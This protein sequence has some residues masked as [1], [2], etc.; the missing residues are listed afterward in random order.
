MNPLFSILMGLMPKF[1][2]TAYNLDAVTAST[3]AKIEKKFRDNLST[4][5]PFFLKLKEQGGLELVNGGKELTYPVII[6]DGNAA[7]YYGDD[8]MQI[9]RPEG[10]Q[11][12]TYSWKQFYSTIRI[13]GIEE[14]M[15]A[16]EG[17]GAK[18]LDG[19]MEQAEV[20]TANK[21]E[22]MLFGDSTGNPGG[23]SVARDWNGLRDLI[24]DTPTTG[25]IGG[26]SRVTYTKLRNQ[27]Y[28]TTISAFN[29]S[30]A[31]RIGM[32]TL[33]MDCTNGNRSP[34]FIPTTVAIW[35]LYQ[36]SLT[37]NERFLMNQDKALTTAGFPNVA[38]MMA[39]V[40]ASSGCAA[41]HLYMLRIAKPR[42]TG[43]MFLVISNQRNFKME[44]FIKPI[45]QDI[46]VAK[47]LTAGQLC[48]DAPYLNGVIPTIT[49]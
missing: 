49:G 29:T 38:F 7:S 45:D 42:S 33:Y 44:P 8:T 31:G 21:F 43:G 16:G 27:I 35:V 23:D 10:L 11:P 2:M 9:S 25:T 36:I 37:T 26:L 40:V 39:P 28:S 32:T 47:V 24:S 20:T 12:L 46:R 3:H 34:N 18:I 30:A 48:T 1:F 4:K 19:R 14:I 17:E 15:N 41:S 5:T 13:D 22:T 6:D